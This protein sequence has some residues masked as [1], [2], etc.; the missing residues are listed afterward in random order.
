MKT[1]KPQDDVL[2]QNLWREKK[3]G[4]EGELNGKISRQ[5]IVGL[6]NLW[7]EKI[8]KQTFDQFCSK[9]LE[10]GIATQRNS[11]LAIPRQSASLSLI[12]FF[13]HFCHTSIRS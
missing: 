3:I 4:L 7:L 13:N 2:Q 1:S 6:K 12:G 10:L 9:F 5:G 8:C 11:P